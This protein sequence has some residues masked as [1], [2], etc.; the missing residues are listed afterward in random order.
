LDASA[1]FLSVPG[2]PFAG[3]IGGLTLAITAHKSGPKA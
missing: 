1:L 3:S 2:L